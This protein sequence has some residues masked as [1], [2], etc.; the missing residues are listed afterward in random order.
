MPR[1]AA[2]DARGGVHPSLG[3]WAVVEGVDLGIEHPTHRMSAWYT[4]RGGAWTPHLFPDPAPGHQPTGNATWTGEWAGV[5]GP[6]AT[7]GTGRARVA[8][9]LGPAAEADLVLEDVPD[10]GTL[11][12]DDMPVGGGRF[13]GSTTA[14]ADTYAAEGQFG[15][16]GRA[17]VVGHASGPAFRSV[18]YGEKD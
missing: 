15:G 4:S 13:T 11:R 16:A 3:G 8:V 14:G 10:L 6:G 12:W 2:P 7:V 9:T 5:H 18:F 17:G 1:A